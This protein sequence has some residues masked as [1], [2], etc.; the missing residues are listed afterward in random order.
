MAK[1]PRT[2]SA[3]ADEA[4]VAATRATCAELKAHLEQ[5]L[6]RL[7]EEI[8]RYP[9]PI[10]RCDEQLGALLEQRAALFGC[11]KRMDEL[12]PGVHGPQRRIRS[13]QSFLDSLPDAADQLERR[14]RAR[15][16][17]QLSQI[18]V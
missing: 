16:E 7:N 1:A 14:L 17:V 6:R 18:V 10:A 3:P 8:R 13:I 5:R 2:R 12:T 9:T 4:G 11:L 15:L